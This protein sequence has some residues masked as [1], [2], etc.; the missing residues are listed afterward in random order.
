[1]GSRVTPRPPHARRRKGP[2]QWLKRPEGPFSLRACLSPGTL[3]VA[4]LMAACLFSG[5]SVV[6][7]THETRAQYAR[8][9]TL[10][11]EKNQ[12]NTEWGRLLL[13]DGTWSTPARI[14][15]IATERLDMRIPDVHD[16]EVIAP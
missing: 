13:E 8:L 2:S 11:Q 5:L 9:Q 12:L 6:V 7:I 16:V 15:K 3:L 1:M 10:E 14:E 4:G